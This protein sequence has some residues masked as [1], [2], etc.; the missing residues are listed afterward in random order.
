MQVL[1]LTITELRFSVFICW[2][3]GCSRRM[4]RSIITLRSVLIFVVWN[5]VWSL[6]IVIAL[7]ASLSCDGKTYQSSEAATNGDDAAHY[8]QAPT[9]FE[10]SVNNDEQ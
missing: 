9:H 1:V 6:L 7:V 3:I 4:R 8:D 5:R 10:N 2:V